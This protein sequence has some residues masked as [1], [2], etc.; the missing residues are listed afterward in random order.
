MKDKNFKI[1]NKTKR[2]ISFILV[3]VIMLGFLPMTKSKAVSNVEHINTLNTSREFDQENYN[4]V[5][6]KPNVANSPKFKE[7]YK[8]YVTDGSPNYWK[9]WW[10]EGDYSGAAYYTIGSEK[11]FLCRNPMLEHPP[12]VNRRFVVAKSG[13]LDY[14]QFTKMADEVADVLYGREFIQAMDNIGLG[15]R[16]R[17]NTIFALLIM[18]FLGDS[19]NTKD[20]E[21]NWQLLLDNF[22]Q[23]ANQWDRENILP[24]IKL[25]VKPSQITDNQIA[26]F[27][28]RYGVEGL[29][30]YLA[31]TGQVIDFS[32]SLDTQE[33][34]N[35]V[36]GTIA[37]IQ[38]GIRDGLVEVVNPKYVAYS[39]SNK[40]NLMI[41]NY[42]ILQKASMKFTVNNELN[43]KLKKVSEN[44][45]LT[46][47]D[48]HGYSLEGAEYGVY[49]TNSDAK[50]NT[51]KLA[52]LRVNSKGESNEVKLS[53]GT[54]HIKEIKAPK[55]FYLDQKVYRV[56]LKDKDYILNVS[57][58]P[59]FDPL[60]IMLKKQDGNKKPLEGAEFEIK[61]YAKT[62][63]TK[64]EIDKL[65]PVRTWKLKT[66][67]DGFLTL[68]ERYKIGGDNFYKDETGTPV[69]LIGT[70]T[71]VETKAPKG[72]SIPKNNF[73]IAY[74]NENGNVTNPNETGTIYNPP[75]VS[76][77]GQKGKFE[78]TKIDIN[79]QEKISN[80]EF[81]ILDKEDRLVGKLVTDE[82]GKAKSQELSL[83]DYKLRETKAPNGY[84]NLKEDI[85]IKI[86]ADGSGNH[87]TKNVIIE[88]SDIASIENANISIKN[89]PQKMRFTLQK[90]D[91]ISASVPQ[92]QDA[93]LEN[94]SYDVILVKSYQKASKLKEGDIVASLKTGK[95][96]KVQSPIL[97]LG[98]YDVVEKESSRGYQTNPVAVRVEGIADGSG[99]ELSSKVQQKTQNAQT[100]VDIYNQKIDELN[101][102]NKMNANGD[103]HRVLEKI[104]AREN[105]LEIKENAT[106]ITSE[107][108]EYGRIS[109]TK[110]QDGKT[111][112]E[113][114]SQ[115][116]ERLAEE[117]IKFNIYDWNNK[118]VD[119]IITDKSGRATTKWLLKGKYTVKQDTHKEGFIDV[120]DF[121][122][123]II[124]NW[125]EYQYNLENYANLKYLK[126]IKKDA[127]TGET[128]PQEGV[129]FEL[130]D[131]KGQIVTHTLRYPE[132]KE[133]SQFVTGKNGIVQLPE[134][135]TT[136]N[137]TLREIKAP[138]GYFLDPNG[139]PIEFNIPDDSGLVKIFIQKVN[140]TPQKGK[141]ILEKKAPILKK[142]EVDKLTGIT[143]LIFENDYL[144]DTKWE[145]RAK[146]DIYSK[147]TK[148]L[149]HKKGDLV[150]TLI[151]KSTGNVESKEVALG[152]YTLKE[153]SLPDK[154]VLDKRSYDIEFSPQRQEIRIHSVT[155]E[156][157]NER[158]DVGFEFTKEFEDDKYF[159]RNPEAE[160]GLFL[161]E[162]YIE[163]DVT[164][165]KDSLLAKTKLKADI[166][167]IVKE[168]VSSPIIEKVKEEADAKE[169]EITEKGNIFETKV[170]TTI[171]EKDIESESKTETKTINKLVVTGKFEKMPI[172][173][174]FYIKELST[175]K[176]YVLDDKKHE[177][178]FDFADTQEKEN[179]I[180]EA[181]IENKLQK[182]SLVI[183]KTE[184][185][186]DKEIP[187]KGAK[188]RLVA[189][190]EIKGQTSI[191]EFIT[192]KDGKISIDLLSK[193]NYYLEEVSSPNG[194]FKDEIKHEIDLN[195]QVEDE[196]IIDLENEKIPEIKTN[197][198]DDNTGKKT[199]NPT[200]TVVIK[201]KVSFK[202]LIIGKT[203]KV[204]GILMDK[205]T[206]KP[207]L[208]KKG[209]P[210]TS[211]L[212]FTAESRQGYVSLLFK[213]DGE[214]LRGKTTVVFEDLYRDDRLLY[215]HKDINDKDQTTKT[216]NPE[217]KTKFVDVNNKQDLL[218]LGKVTLTDNVSFKDLVIGD[219]YELKLLVMN[220]S[221]NKPLLD[222]DGKQV[223]ATKKFV[224]ETKDGEI[225]VDVNVDLERLRG[226]SIVA[227]E[228]LIFK[229]EVIAS[230]KDIE[231]VNQTIVVNKPEIKTKFADFRGNKEIYGLGKTKLIDNVYYNNLVVGKE[232][233]LKMRIAIKNSEEFIKDDKG[234]DLIVTKKFTAEKKEGIIPVEVE[235]DLSKYQGKELVA[236]E[237]LY[238]QGIE[239]SIHEDINDK[240]QTI[241]IKTLNP[242]TSDN[243]N[244]VLLS[245]ILTLS[246]V[247]LFIIS[248]KNKSI[249]TQK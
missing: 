197:A 174:K 62:N 249:K 209:N 247:I 39:N 234:N 184:M 120:E 154:Y 178:G 141:L 213:V 57:D 132:T 185:G 176:N 36:Y 126:I 35:S 1:K 27:S 26:Q 163:N 95:D 114:S 10:S 11:G 233:E 211:G 186:S 66:D 32:G 140:N 224:A 230:H 168:E 25:F 202:D 38:T 164:I 103:E 130:Y 225:G 203:Y 133:I 8:K 53:L 159:T 198:E 121:T 33:K 223:M 43:L 98:I 17:T 170:I 18:S 124:G 194:Y 183:V 236:F 149:I 80:A 28:H 44:K 201:D 241:K 79:S 46:D 51:N 42:Q 229:G 23:N 125:A 15:L 117:G 67:E 235:I 7:A 182:I 64:A 187:V 101:A 100:L 37:V 16:P 77:E 150:D 14:T 24:D 108:P 172:D 5:L 84:V 148:T 192:D 216:L 231:D 87:L 71:F 110:H 152:K 118:L 97:E 116:G 169:A 19:Q 227:F 161:A 70:Y 153:V 238:Y 54:Y 61:Y 207:L 92:G 128:I 112:L 104:K 127:E 175:N 136:G 188:Y 228:E 232:Y 59:K 69:G 99:K 60:N 68:D 105:K 109:I 218:P 47:L 246:S 96:G 106:V 75:I 179:T 167:S 160:F 6:I 63:L 242:K 4:S 142:T 165:K 146:E 208:D 135:V 143:R 30:Y 52:T 115:S 243:F 189:V 85:K 94:A 193:G 195:E 129:T 212:E 156:K 119:E 226:T 171:V 222:K 220:K 196:K 78:I 240:D 102:L 122:V 155:E 56:E 55:G 93:T 199:H 83:G 81:N 111:G 73:Y 138:T 131:Q 76:N 72:Y 190:D 151:T 244:V 107:I 180:K 139:E 29:L 214:V 177:T 2:I 41:S 13:S 48:K 237:K 22:K 205:E 74:V 158:K 147:D 245:G 215:S 248:R 50:A 86:L 157:Y 217:I 31:G 88:K 239:L 162:D 91:F 45:E 137:Y 191:G 113:N 144:A 3:L 204:K 34:Y 40:D 20:L 210:Y 58:K 21:D 206:N 89:A 166:N 221:T 123:E 181:E 49:K 12:T 173:G 90:E 82:K 65:T 219:E 134:K 200:K 145:L 9:D